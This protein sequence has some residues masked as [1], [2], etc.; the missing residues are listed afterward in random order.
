[1]S[2]S[3]YDGMTV[4][5]RLFAAGLL[6]KFDEALSARDREAQVDL[7]AAVDLEAGLASTL[8]G[9]PPT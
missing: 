2:Q 5:E 8:L 9:D 7:L 1:M 4:N 6:A 3:P